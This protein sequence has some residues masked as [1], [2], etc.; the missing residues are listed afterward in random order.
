MKYK[1]QKDKKKRILFQKYEL[2]RK[3]YKSI[4]NNTTLNNTLRANAF[5]FLRSLP[6]NSSITRI[7]NRCIETGRGNAIY[8]KFRLSRLSFR[9]AAQNG[10]LPGVFKSSW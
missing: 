1:N 6:K 9:E 8:K 2:D 3:L 5:F 10:L 4:A 7:R